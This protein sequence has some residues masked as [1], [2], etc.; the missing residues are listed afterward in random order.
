[1]KEI[2][3]NHDGNIDDLVSYLLLLQA[4]EIKLLGVSAIDADGYLE[5]SVEVCR[6]MTDQFNLRGDKLA[7]AKSNSRAVNQF[8]EAWRTASYSFNSLPL[9][10]ESGKITTGEAAE[11]AHLD[12]IDKLRKAAK[13]VTLVMT[14]PLTD[15][16]RALEV[17][18]KIETK[19][20]RLFWMGGSLDGHGNVVQVNADGTQEWNAFWDPFAV[21]RVFQSEIPMQVIG[22]ESSEELPLTNRLK[23]HWA[24]LR[25]YPV[26]DLVGQAYSLLVNPPIQSAQL[27]FWDVLTTINALYPEVVIASEKRTV[28]VRTVGDAAGRLEDDEN[29]REITLVTKADKDF[30][31]KK[32]DELMMQTK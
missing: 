4:P 20:D 1:M 19:I 18:P 6:K 12:M 30:F 21:D 7:I 17:D 25:K 16:A 3:F 15:L 2:Y 32:F 11:P 28:K 10:N 27:Y 22:L 31:F 24:S 23:M 5:P 13:P 29:G 26:V 14:G 9:L 8:P